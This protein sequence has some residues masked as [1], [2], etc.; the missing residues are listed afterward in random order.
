MACE[1]LLQHVGEVIEV[2]ALGGHAGAAFLNMKITKLP[3]CF[4]YARGCPGIKNKSTG[5]SVQYSHS[6]R[7]VVPEDQIQNLKT[8]PQNS[9]QYQYAHLP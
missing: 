8:A 7:P 3:S 5:I 1:C 4:K 6:G 9:L 2:P